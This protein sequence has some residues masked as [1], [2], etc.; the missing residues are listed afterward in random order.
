[1]GIDDD[2]AAHILLIAWRLINSKDKDRWAACLAKQEQVTANEKCLA[3]E[4]EVLHLQSIVDDQQV[5]IKDEHQKNKTKYALV[6]DAGVPD[7]T[8]TLP[9]QY[10][11]CLLKKGTFC[12]LFYFT[13]KGLHEASHAS[14]SSDAEA[15]VIIQ[16]ETGSHTFIPALA[17]KPPSPSFVANEDLSWEQFG[18]A[19]PRMVCA[20]KNHNWP[21]DCMNMYIIFWSAI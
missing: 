19:T 20:M 5:A 3:D 8:F 17:A 2:R 1:L 6:W 4:A 21:E 7:N 12:P 16:G 10:A 11:A 15:M 14:L 9:S 18:E 13:N